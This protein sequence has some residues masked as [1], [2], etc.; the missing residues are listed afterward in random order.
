MSPEAQEA[1][2]DAFAYWEAVSQQ[3]GSNITFHPITTNP[4]S[5]QGTWVIVKVDTKQAEIEFDLLKNG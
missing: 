1:V 3:N 2:A 5:G 4:T